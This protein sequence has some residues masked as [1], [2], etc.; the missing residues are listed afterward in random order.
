MGLYHSFDFLVYPDGFIRRIEEGLH[1]LSFSAPFLC[2]CHQHSD[3]LGAKAASPLG[4]LCF[5][6]LI[7]LLLPEAE[8]CAHV[9]RQQQ[10]RVGFVFRGRG[11]NSCPGSLASLDGAGAAAGGV[12]AMARVPLEGL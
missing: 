12:P 9:L 2:C 4:W 1:I 7:S 6:T 3:L 10:A 8:L 5:I 11:S